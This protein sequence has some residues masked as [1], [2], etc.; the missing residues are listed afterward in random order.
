MTLPS[1]VLDIFESALGATPATIATRGRVLT[2]A[3]LAAVMAAR[4]GR[5]HPERS[6]HDLALEIWPLVSHHTYGGRALFGGQRH[7]ILPRVLTLLVLHDGLVVADPLESVYQILIS[8]S[9]ADA[10]HALNG[11]VGQLADV[12]PL[13]GAGVL[14]LTAL[15]PA[16]QEANRATIL[17]AM[18][19]EPDLRVFTDLLEAAAS[20]SAFPGSFQRT[21]APQVRDLHRL[22]GLDTPAPA[23]LEIATRHVGALAAAVIE[24]SWQ[25]AVASLDPTCDLAFVG[26]LERHLAEALVEQ[27]TQA[28]LGAGRHV[29]TLAL[30]QVPNLDTTRL[31]AAD[32]LAIRREDAFES[33]RHGVRQAL[34][35]LDV[36]TRTG[37]SKASAHGAFEE[38]MRENSRALRETSK[39]A[40][41][42]DR[43]KDASVPASLGVITEF[44]VAPFGPLHAAAA[45]GA[46]S[47]GTVIWQWMIARHEVGGRAVTQRYLAMLG[48]Y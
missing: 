21:Y 28:D 37:V 35:Q 12:E 7:D 8:R 2:A 3:D 32:A 19:L 45:A 26:H 15:R 46:V 39:R 10:V 11:V 36:A 13:I 22:F 30:G 4:T 20:V 42:R 44:A 43:L 17:E 31:S 23:T 41:F 38:T 25:F 16:L 47:L 24:V 29:S 27:G 5:V 34:D 1:T 9:E 14:R 33:F 40:S 48:R 6:P 18:G